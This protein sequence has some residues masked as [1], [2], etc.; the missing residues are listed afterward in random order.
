MTSPFGGFASFLIISAIGGKKFIIVGWGDGFLFFETH[1]HR[2]HC[3]SG[4][5]HVQMDICIPVWLLA[6]KFYHFWCYNKLIVNARIV[7]AIHLISC[8]FPH[9]V[10][11]VISFVF[12]VFPPFTHFRYFNRISPWI[13]LG[14]VKLCVRIVNRS[15]LIVVVKYNIVVL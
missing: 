14:H 1:K 15:I 13:V 9:R 8:C 11:S 5:Q 10:I 3:V 12:A 2:T 6:C 7:I 4:T